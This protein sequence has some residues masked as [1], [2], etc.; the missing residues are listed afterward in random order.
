MN[1]DIQG[2]GTIPNS[3]GTFTYSPTANVGIIVANDIVMGSPV[4]I[5]LIFTGSSKGVFLLDAPN[6]TQGG[7]FIEP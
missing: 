2:D 4:D 5:T 1:H 7:S 3:S 6:G